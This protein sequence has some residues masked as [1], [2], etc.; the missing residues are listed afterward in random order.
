MEFAS[1][2]VREFGLATIPLSY[3]YKAKSDYKVL[4]LCFAKHPDTL[5][6]ALEVLHRFG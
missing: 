1:R 2:L 6:K 3:F 4:R 5:N